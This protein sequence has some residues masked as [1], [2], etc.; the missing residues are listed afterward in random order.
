M[1]NPA[2]RARP[3]SARRSFRSLALRL[4]GA[5]CLLAAQ[6]GVAGSLQ[7][8]PIS[9][10]FSEGQQAQA[11]WLSNAGDAPIRAQVRVMQWSQS[12]GSE[13]L[14]PSRELVPSPPIVEIA[15]GRQQLVR[16]VRPEATAAGRELAYRVLVDEL[17]DAQQAADAGLQFLL[18]YSIPL[19]VLPAG[20]AAQDAPG[21]RP[22]TDASTLSASLAGS[23]QDTHLTVVNRG[24]RRVRLSQLA[25]VDA[26]GTHTMLVPGLLGYVLAGQRMQWPVSLPPG[27][28]H[29]AR[30][31]VRLNDDQEPQIL[32]LASSTP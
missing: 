18:Q 9:L 20:A 6:T 3:A 29:G 31:E 32:P 19:F 2:S 24:A 26:A 4:A 22:P 13:R 12:E 1:A 5:C 23:G 27:G 14:E 7:V 28:F 11:L 25:Q 30:L 21:P 16:I 8:A 17:P 15:P 10:E